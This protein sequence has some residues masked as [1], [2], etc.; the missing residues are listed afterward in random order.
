[1]RK[2]TEEVGQEGTAKGH[3]CH[4][5]LILVNQDLNQKVIKNLEGAEVGLCLPL[6]VTPKYQGQ[7][8][9]Q[10]HPVDLGHIVD[11]DQ[12][13]SPAQGQGQFLNQGQGLFLR[14][15]QKDHLTLDSQIY[16]TARENEGGKPDHWR[17]LTLGRRL[18]DPDRTP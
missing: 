10:G 12:E 9:G 7:N 17:M 16:L 4:R 6:A 13:P 18:N 3:L 1:M 15:R 14:C 5:I 8:Q 2:E 11:Q